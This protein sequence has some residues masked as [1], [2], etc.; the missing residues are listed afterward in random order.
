MGH[1]KGPANTLPMMGGEGPYGK[2]EMGGMFT[3]L[4]VRD[5][6]PANG[7]VGWYEASPGSTAQRVSGEPDFG[8]PV[9]RGPPAPRPPEIETKMDHE[10]HGASGGST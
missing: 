2:L 1:M 8:S 6:L 5:D 10:H 9:R 4:K 3:V 7:E